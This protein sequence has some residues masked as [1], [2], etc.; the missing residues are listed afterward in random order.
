M[1]ETMEEVAMIIQEETIKVMILADD[2]MLLGESEVEVQEQLNR[3]V[4]VLEQH[5][6]KVNAGKS[7][8]VKRIKRT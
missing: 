8:V 2:L 1:N 3:W 5:G 4:R 6:K 7:K